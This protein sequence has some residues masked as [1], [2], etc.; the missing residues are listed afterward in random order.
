MALDDELHH[1]TDHLDTDFENP[2][3]RGFREVMEEV[4][5]DSRVFDE[6]DHYF[7]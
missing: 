6:P 2:Y 3:E 1:L 7:H 4:K 5:A